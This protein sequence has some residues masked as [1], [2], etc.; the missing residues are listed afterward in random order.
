MSRRF[1]CLLAIGFVFAAHG[2]GDHGRDA[3]ETIEK[4]QRALENLDATPTSGYCPTCATPAAHPAERR[5][6]CARAICEGKETQLLND[7]ENDAIRKAPLVDVRAEA[8]KLEGYFKR[9]WSAQTA[10]NR[11]YQDALKGFDG[12]PTDE[13]KRLFAFASFMDTVD[14]L[15]TTNGRAVGRINIHLEVDLQKTAAKLGDYRIRQVTTLKEMGDDFFQRVYQESLQVDSYPVDVVIKEKYPNMSRE[16]AYR[17]EVEITE[18][19]LREVEAHPEFRSYAEPLGAANIRADVDFTAAAKVTDPSEQQFREMIH[20]RSGLRLLQEVIDRE[21]PLSKIAARYDSPETFEPEN[22]RRQLER[23]TENAKELADSRHRERAQGRFMAR[24]LARLT[25]AAQVLPNDRQLAAAEQNAQA[26]IA[27]IENKIL[28]KFSKPT[29]DAATP[30]LRST[31]FSYPPTAERFRRSF[32]DFVDQMTKLERPGNEPRGD[33]ALARALLPSKGTD[34]RLGD[35]MRQCDRPAFQQRMV[36][37]ASYGANGSIQV[38]WGTTRDPQFG[39]FVLGHELG[40]RLSD[41]FD[42]IQMSAH[43]AQR[44]TEIRACLRAKQALG[45]KPPDHYLSEDWADWIGAEVAGTIGPNPWCWRIDFAGLKDGSET[46]S[47]RDFAGDDEHS[48]PFFRL[49]QI[50]RQSGR[51]LPPGCKQ[52]ILEENP[53]IAEHYDCGQPPPAGL[54]AGTGG[55]LPGYGLPLGTGTLAPGP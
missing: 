27:T 43:S 15:E 33:Y 2:H 41:I 55:L 3:V 23:L 9:W 1:A 19:L 14:K 51:T 32:G 48:T 6:A 37:D 30:R 4:S 44:R 39:R 28:P 31:R 47:L 16:Q 17:R 46:L 35:L 45:P 13:Q 29:R 8:A 40:H 20:T 25:Y 53:M 21:S 42:Q 26:A 5:A 10:Q 54:P 49:V 36:S 50:H 34:E 38:G 11:L 12:K 7:L 52:A 24:C 18:K 22:R